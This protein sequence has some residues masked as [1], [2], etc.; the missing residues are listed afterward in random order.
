MSHVLSWITFFPLLGALGILFVPKGKDQLIKTIA[1]AVTFVPLVLALGML[2]SYDQTLQGF[3]FVEMIPWISS[4][5][6]NFHMGVDGMSFLMVL[7]S[8]M[9]SF[10]CIFASW[11]I[12]KYVKGYFC[13]FLLL[14]V[15]MLGVF[16]SLDFFLFYVFWEVMLLPMYFLVGI[17]GGERKEYAAIKFFLYTLLGSVLMLVGLLALYFYSTG[18]DGA[19]PATF[20]LIELSKINWSQYTI[21][22]FGYVLPFDTTVWWLL[23]MGFAVKVP[24][25]PF[26]TWLPWAHV[27]A[28][29]A[30][31]VILAG[32]L[33]KMGTYGFLRINFWLLPDATKSFGMV[34][35]IMG[36]VNIIYGA[37]CAMAQKDLKKLVA[38][39][40]VSHMG[41]CLLGMAVFT[42]G[43]MQGAI[44]QMFNHG[45]SAAMMFMLVGILYDRLHHRQIVDKNGNL[46][47]G[48]IAQKEPIITAAWMVA[49]F[50][51]LGLPGLNGFI[52]EAMVFLGAFPVY[53]VITSIAAIG[54]VLTAAYL[55]WMVQRVFLGP[56]TAQHKDESGHMHPAGEI[57]PLKWHEWVVLVPLAILCLW[58][59]IM[60]Q[61]LL[62]LFKVSANTLTEALR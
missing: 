18:P 39:S 16:C 52:S 60:P 22:I 11:N 46:G 8:T 28:P 51:S 53:K 20:N 59:G 49:V 42:A 44:L 14:H 4:L 7:L 24:I 32:V 43:G 6:V 56:Y 27:Q 19:S 34:L 3:Q 38:Y 1:A 47:F 21:N 54:I 45:I 62:N 30:V 61:P 35:A 10:L 13:M 57:P 48:G 9:L 2:S 50:S 12:K 55:L 40:S 33:L 29:T 26:H 37:L 25:V 17:W 36:V 58:I 5:N 31:S 23:F 41:Y 15:G